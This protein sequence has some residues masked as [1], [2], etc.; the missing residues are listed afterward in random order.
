[1][2]GTL[3]IDGAAIKTVQPGRSNAATA[4]DLDGDYLVPGLVEL[5][6][7]NLERHTTPRP[8]VQW[9]RL[10]AALAHDA[11][12]A[13]AGI[14]TVLDA[15]RLGRTIEDGE[16]LES[17]SETMDAIR[18]AQDQG[19][20]RAEHFFH[21][22]CEIS[23][24]E[25]LQQFQKLVDAPLLKLVSV[26]DHTPGQRQ[27]VD[28]ERLRVYYTRKYGMTDERFAAFT[29]ER[30][31]AQARYAQ[32]YR[33][34]IVEL[35]HQRGIALASH[36]DA[37]P[38]HVA[39]AIA[40]G[41]VIAEFPTTL[42]AA[43]LA[44]RYGMAVLVGGPNIVLGGS[45]SG[46]IAATDLVRAGTADI[47]SS[48]YVP[49]SLMQAAFTIAGGEQR[50]PQALSMVS[51]KPARAVGLADRGELAAGQRADVVRVRVADDMPQ[52]R[53]VLRAGRRVV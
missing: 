17:L 42:E 13:A 38:E 48:D 33:S 47:V 21:L 19:L 8:K 2:A 1:V 53:E 51:S 11:Q 7:D 6:T 32:R 44:H 16:S 18:Q 37:K 45:H 20:A 15:I 10:S 3:V 34:E 5:H 49:S 52:V 23:C 31:E 12:M 40:E 46:N 14:T 4:V 39:E 27:F 43:E 36:D 35:S 24:A 25:T 29:A 41:M 30:M 50:L 28:P 22:R 26:M 9:P